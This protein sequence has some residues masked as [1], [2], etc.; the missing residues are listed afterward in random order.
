MRALSLAAVAA[1]L[2]LVGPASAQTVQITSSIGVNTTWGPS[3]TVVGSVFWV[4][5]SIAVNAGVTLNIQP[6]VVVKF[7][8]GTSFTVN[9]ALRA[10]GTSGSNIFFT[11]VHDDAVGG[12][13]NGNGNTTVP[14]ASDWGGIRFPDA[15]TDFATR[16]DYGD[17]RFAGY[18]T[19]GALT[20]TSSSDS[21]TNSVI[22]RSYTG[23]D[24]AG[25]AAPV[26]SNTT[27]EASTLTPIVLDFTAAPVFSSL[28][29]SSANNGYDAFGLRGSTLT[30]G[31]NA[32][33]P[34]RGATV[35]LNPVTNVTYV[36]LGSLTI[37]AGASLTVNP[38]VVIK[39]NGSHTI[40]VSGTLTMNGTAAAGDTITITS[41]HDDNFGLPGDTN[42]NGS[43]SAPARGDWNRIV[44]LP[45]SSG[46]LSRCRFKFG[47]NSTSQGMVEMTNNAIGVSN[48]LLSDAGHGL[49]ILGIS[50]PTI[51]NVAI[52]NCSSTPIYMSVS[53]N[54]VFTGVSFLANAITA[55]GLNGE[56]IAVDSRIALRSVAGFINITYY[57]MNGQLVMQS[58]AILRIDPGV[59][60][61]NQQGGG[62][63]QIDGGLIADGKPDSLI[64]FTSDRDDLYGNPPDT[65]GDGSITNPAVG[66]WT[67]I[68]FTATSNDAVSKLDNCRVTYGSS[69]T[70]GGVWCTSS[71]PAITN[72]VFSRLAYGIRVD[73]DGSPNIDQCDFNNLTSAPI[74]MSALS[75]P[76][77]ATTNVYSSNAY[78]ALA[79]ISE[80]LSQST[81]IRYRPGVG[82]PTFAY[83]PI[84]TITVSAGVTLSIDPQV[85]IKPSGNFA[86]FTVNGALNVVGSNN[87]T[88]R[89]VFSSRRDDN[90]AYGGDTTPADVA[91][92]Q[93][94]DWG[95]INFTDTAVDAACVIRNVLFQF[96]GQGGNENGTI[97]TASASPRLASL[98]FFQNVTAMTFGGNSQPVVDS[99]AVLNCTN[100][101]I[102]F[103]L[104][105]N[106]QFPA[107]SRIVL[108][109][110]AYTCLGL[111]GETIA[112]DVTT[113][114][115]ALGNNP[116]I[117]YCPTGN[118]TIGFGAKWTIAPGVVIKLGRIFIDPIGTTIT[119]DGALVADGKPDSLIVFTASTDDAFGGDIKGDG[120]ATSPTSGQW[121][122]LIF[123]PISND[124]ATVIDNCRF[125]YGGQ[126]SVGVLRFISSGPTV[127]NSVTTSNYMGAWIE[128][129]ATPVFTNVNF[130]SS[131]NVP[132]NMSLVSNPTFNNV[133]FLGG[134]YTALGVLLESIAQDARWP[135]RAVSGR[136]NMPWLL[137]GTLTVGLGATL[138][139]QPG[140]IV[141]S[142]NGIINVQRAF[143]AEGRV[144]EPESLI[145]FTSYRDDFYG[146]DTNNDGTLTVP[147]A[148]DWG[149][150]MV[151]GTAIDALVRFKNCAF[152]YG[153][154]GATQGAIRCVN[155][156]PSVDS[157]MFSLNSTGI[158]VEGSS[159]PV[160]HG[161]SFFGNSSF[162]INNTGGSFCINAEGN[163]WGAVSG[164]LDPATG[165]LCALTNAGTGDRASDNVDYAPFATTGVLNP[166][167][168]DVSLNGQVLAYDASLVL[169]YAVALVSL[170]PLQLSVADV[171]GVGGVTAGDASLILQ[172]VA[173]VI[174]AFPAI[175]N[176][177]YR[178]AGDIAAARSVL[179][180][181][182]GTGDVSL[183][184]AVRDGDGWRVPVNVDAPGDVYALELTLEGGAFATLAGLES[185]ADGAIAAHHAGEV[186]AR[187]AL[188]GV[189]PLGHGQV[190]WLRFAGADGTFEMPRLA[191]ARVN[192]QGADRPAPAPA[193]PKVSF[194]APPAPNP[195][196]DRAAFRIGVAQAD[197]GA[198]GSVRIVDVTGRAVRT[199][200]NGALE[201]GVRDL[202]W[203]LADDTGR[204]VP[205]G[206]YFLR[207]NVGSLR[208]TH[209]VIV[210]R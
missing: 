99:T 4:R 126:G 71:A 24:C 169:Q 172:Y 93:A 13:T 116:N 140:V 58:P 112:Q 137:Q 77:I 15:T 55:L 141:K 192:E 5:N 114:V 115:R 144:V 80:T 117:A 64:V 175:S 199:L 42:N 173:G 136:N 73:G 153:G 95:G 180:R 120:A 118:I 159:N 39:P 129:N 170:T 22:R 125:R 148:G 41:I 20:F 60:I 31:V 82:S 27:I 34:K 104:I 187:V 123:N 133:Q 202:V 189:S 152:R 88:G 78:N 103:S 197:A 179:A 10:I 14:N 195:A 25:S 74:L 70:D 124:V 128:G 109:N 143:Q 65:N 177:N 84:G 160:V 100:L 151:D 203:D 158:S 102:T 44:Y 49:A 130:D 6:G 156:S 183:G 67:Y 176:L 46:S 18:G 36:L 85:V 38:G 193:S 43:I 11:S 8:P 108:A 209:R 207:A 155:S 157:C 162:G 106:P 54:P 98:E 167:I 45:G 40:T 52:N 87:T 30:S 204:R 122:G 146:G 21:V 154:N 134:S 201:A 47:S 174:P 48:S 63:F 188:A 145:V 94:G 178:P 127:T 208:A 190:A 50:S 90:P 1:A 75:N 56:P 86:V 168:G 3:G 9:G 163:W 191:W 89:V 59:V 198:T 200:V 37:N 81:R 62:G 28:V 119:I 76:T 111:F 171:S 72:T 165:G 139:V 57:V 51:T 92:P 110:N 210:V 206:L 113:R 205:A 83:L 132:V 17:I 147:A 32:T 161:S 166:F 68:R 2:L 107:P 131:A 19:T 16:F 135:I 150:I 142:N 138:T 23:L 66:N 194:A 7:D 186:E 96:G 35:G 105:S 184:T 185:T 181:M 79:L 97:S 53:A 26:M 33:L 164:P 12:D 149:S 121:I 69:S 182:S 101:P 61:K 91:A 196:R 29:F